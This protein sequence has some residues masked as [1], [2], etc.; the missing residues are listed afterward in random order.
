MSLVRIFLKPIVIFL[1]PI[2]VI[3]TAIRLLITPL[4]PQIEYQLPNFPKDEFGFT[5]ED[6]L[7]FSRY[8][9]DYL[10]N[11]SSIEYL[12]DLTFKDGTR[13]FNERELSHMNDVKVVV[14]GMIRTWIAILGFL[15]LVGFLTYR[16]K[17]QERFWQAVSGGG[18]LT[19]GIIGMIIIS[20]LT[21]FEA[22]FIGFHKVFFIGDTWLFYTSDTLIRL[23]P[24]KFWSDAFIGIGILSILISVFII[25]LGNKIAKKTTSR[26]LKK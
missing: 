17:I 21:N 8:A 24:E 16:I 23:F 22:L 6:R 9:I 1:V 7:H 4:Y 20:V 13:L 26:S 18:W 15:I 12:G 2:L 3:M 25:A 11:D 14:Q 10:I 5:T 19:L